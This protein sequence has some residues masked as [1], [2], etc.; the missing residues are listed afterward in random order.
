MFY[1]KAG[2]RGWERYTANQIIKKLL[3]FFFQ[4]TRPKTLANSPQWAGLEPTYPC[5]LVR[6][7]NYFTIRDHYAGNVTDCWSVDANGVRVEQAQIIF[8]E[9]IF[10]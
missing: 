5:F 10:F 2:F 4:Q 3:R 6:H 7:A 9:W 1:W 8:Y